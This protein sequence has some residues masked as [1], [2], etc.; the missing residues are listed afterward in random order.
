MQYLDS[1]ECDNLLSSFKNIK[2]ETDLEPN[3]FNLL[4]SPVHLSKTIMNLLSNAV[5]VMPNGGIVSI[6]TKTCYLDEP[7]YGYETIN[8]GEY[9]CL[10]I[11]DTGTGISPTDINKIFE[12]FYTKKIMGRSGS[13]LGMSVVWGTVKDHQG[14]I[15]VESSLNN[16]TQIS[17]Y[18]P[19]VRKKVA[20]A[21]TEL[22][23]Q[24]YI[25]QGESVLIIDDIQDQ[26]AI[27]SGILSRLGYI[28]KTVDSGE[29]AV[30]YL[31]NNFVDLLIL[32][33]IMDPGMDGLDTYK[34]ILK[35]HPKQRAI[36]ASGYS[37]TSKVKEALSLGAHSYIKKPYT[38]EKFGIAVRAALDHKKITYTSNRTYSEKVKNIDVT[39]NCTSTLVH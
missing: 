36:I 12:P 26:R 2:I 5:E 33:M 7:K 25:G 37:E 19:V 11:K 16:G 21:K 17:L 28:V 6:S 24:D 39:L 32:D 1:L 38:L 4:G 10:S 31:E 8:E 27:A 15:D 18:F 22:S 23:I 13:G 30:Q 9:V 20:T 35:K 3:L 29:E 34:E 14:F